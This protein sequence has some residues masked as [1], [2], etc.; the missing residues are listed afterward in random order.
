MVAGPAASGQRCRQ[1]RRGA[2]SAAANA[3]VTDR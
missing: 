2:G 1:I 3:Q